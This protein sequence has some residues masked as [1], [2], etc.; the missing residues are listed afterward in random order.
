MSALFLYLTFARRQLLVQY[1][2]ASPEQELRTR[3]GKIKRRAT[4]AFLTYENETPIRIHRR[5]M[6]L[7][8]E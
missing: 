1:N 4:V 3:R 8:G 2:A 5:L 6:D 7:Y